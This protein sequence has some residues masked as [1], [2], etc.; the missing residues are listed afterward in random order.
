MSKSPSTTSFGHRRAAS[1]GGPGEDLLANAS[2]VVE[3]AEEMMMQLWQRVG[4]RGVHYTH[5]PNWLRDNDYLHWGH[6]PQLPSFRECFGS[7]FRIHT[8]TGNIWTHLLGT[9]CMS[10]Y[11]RKCRFCFACVLICHYSSTF[12]LYMLPYPM[13]II[14]SPAWHRFTL[15]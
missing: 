1:Y 6:R 2:R 5:L 14:P 4:W 8:E 7:I 3:Q 12:R 10:L 11:E 15:G 13:Y 9:Y